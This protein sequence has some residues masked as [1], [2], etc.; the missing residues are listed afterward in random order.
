MNQ[1]A[2]CPVINRVQGSV[3]V[4]DLYSNTFL[5]SVFFGSDQGLFRGTFCRMALVWAFMTLDMVQD[6]QSFK[7][8]EVMIGFQ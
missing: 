5:D 4:Q 1:S 2:F 7:T 8:K 6:M 3:R